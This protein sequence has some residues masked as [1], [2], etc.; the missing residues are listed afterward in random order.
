MPTTV[1]YQS[2]DVPVA[3]RADYWRHVVG[4]TVAPLELRIDQGLDLQEKLVVGDV[5]PVRV[6]ELLASA[7]GGASR[8][9]RLIRRSDPDLCKIDV[10]VQGHGIV[11]Q[12][13]RQAHLTP[14]DVAFVDLSRPAKWTLAA[15]RAVAGIFPRSLLPLHPDEMARVTAV[16]IPGDQGGG[17]LISSLARQLSKHLDDVA[18]DGARLGT[19]VLDLITVALAARLDRGA[20]VPHD[21]RQRALLRRIHAYIEARLG[22]PDLSPGEIAAAHHVSLRYLYK[23]F[24]T[25]Q[26]SVAGWIRA[27][28]LER[29]RRDLLDPTLQARPVSAIAARWGL[30]NAAH[31][32]RTFRAAYGVAPVEYRTMANSSRSR[33]G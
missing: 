27:R 6:T 8:T 16:R 30:T 7:P 22:D 11:E 10:A 23:L 19:A 28:R 9:P 32:S 18:P 29:C 21:T 33:A 5:G 15:G 12:D 26:T 13:G 3:S 31:F 25:Q 24:E 2:D 1:V 14:G 4:D 20:Q 17:A